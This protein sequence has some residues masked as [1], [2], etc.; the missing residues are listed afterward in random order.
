M[1]KQVSNRNPNISR[2]DSLLESITNDIRGSFFSTIVNESSAEQRVM[3]FKE[4]KLTSSNPTVC[5]T[6][7]GS[8]TRYKDSGD[9]LAEHKYDAHHSDEHQFKEVDPLS[10]ASLCCVAAN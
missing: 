4:K 9:I 1:M 8:H 7:P 3:E 10:K 5:S 2:L 6:G